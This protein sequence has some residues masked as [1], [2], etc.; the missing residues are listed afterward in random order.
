ML[1]KAL[2]QATQKDPEGLTDKEKELLK[3]AILRYVNDLPDCAYADEVILQY[4]LM[5]AKLGFIDL[6]NELKNKIF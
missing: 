1:Q 5:A 2:K 4:A 3:T 6:S